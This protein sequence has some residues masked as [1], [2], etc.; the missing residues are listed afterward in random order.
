MLQQLQR[1]AQALRQRLARFQAV[2]RIAHELGRAREVQPGVGEFGQWLFQV[3][4]V[5]ER[6]DQEIQRGAGFL[7]QAQAARLFVQV[8]LQAD[9]RARQSLAPRTH[10]GTDGIA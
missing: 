4:V 6:F 5:V 10:R 3:T 8:V 1:H 2:L 9:R 7:G